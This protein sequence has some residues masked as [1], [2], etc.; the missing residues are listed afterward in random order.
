MIM[1]IFSDSVVYLLHKE[2]GVV[3][4]VVYDYGLDDG[5]VEVRWAVEVRC[6]AEAKGFF[7]LA[8]VSR[9]GLGPTQPPVQWAPGIFSPV[10]KRGR[11]MT[12]TTH[13]HLVPRS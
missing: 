7:P 10:V 5:A 3:K 4:S 2:A 9:S 11:G 8:S 1:K 12:L 6:P 13:P